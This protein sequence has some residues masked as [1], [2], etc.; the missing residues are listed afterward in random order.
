MI[1]SKILSLLSDSER[2]QVYTLGW[3]LIVMA[4]LETAGVASVFP[5]MAVVANP[6]LVETNRHLGFVFDAFGFRSKEAFFLFLGVGML[7]TL[8]VSNGLAALI[9]W[10]MLRFGAL[11]SHSLSTR[12]LAK[13]LARPY[14]FFVNQNTSKLGSNILGEVQ[15]V[16]NGV[17][18]PGMQI[19]AR[20]LVVTCIVGLLIVADPVLASVVAS[21]LGGAYG[22]LYLGVRK[23]VTRI[24]AARLDANRERF[25]TA[26]EA[27]NGVKELKLSGGEGFYLER[28][29]R[30]SSRHSRHQ[31]TIQ[32]ISQLPRYGV[33]VIA[34]G[35][36]VLV[37]LYF[38]TAGQTM[39]Q[40]IP[41]VSL[42]AFG[43]YRLL[44]AIQQIFAAL[45]QIR[46]GRPA[47]DALAQDLAGHREDRRSPETPAVAS[48]LPLA[49]H[50]E[51]HDVTF[52]YPNAREE[53]VRKLNVTIRANSRVAFVGATGC[54]KTTTADLLVGLL[55]PTQG[56][57]RVDGIVVDGE[58]R[59][60]WQQNVGSVPQHIYLTDDTVAQNIAFAVR[61]GS[62]DI[63]AVKRAARLA[64]I[65]DFIMSLPD[66]YE[67][68][69]GERGVRLSGGQR[70]RIGIARALYRDPAVLV[71]DEAT[72]SLDR[73]TE[74]A[75]ET[76]VAQLGRSKTVII[77]AHRLATV[78]SCDLIHVMENGCVTVT[79]TYDELIT[80]S[81]LFRELV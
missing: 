28:Y 44:P 46:H 1:V 61:P 26:N 22:C 35:G 47:L 6:Q 49:D 52:R 45:T 66:G 17:L 33:E 60:R 51:L 74:R 31:S 77:V 11:R 72:S 15:N 75:I 50:I 70:Q 63:A 3:L 29:S 8:V 68:V 24:G 65:N 76:A 40:A 7:A 34:F 38:S 5:F 20:T 37:I 69:V 9:T 23:A 18:L 58:S 32:A 14:I 13:Y 67:T 62:I 57:I 21:V 43:G 39:Q 53:A 10:R 48:P 81:K 64:S 16:V 59:R 25:R 78:R 54:G 55:E 2:R 19:V 41:L 36:V 27:L 4:F 80:S 30:A 71:F 79:G 73:G 12:L 56:S 42:Y